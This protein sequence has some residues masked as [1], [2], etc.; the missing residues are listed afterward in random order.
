MRK[1][2]AAALLFISINLFAEDTP[3]SCT[4]WITF[5]KPI[6]HRLHQV[7]TEGND[8]LYFSGYAWHNRYTYRPEKIKSFNENAWGGGLG[9]GF[10][11]EK[12]NFHGLYA[13]AFM[14]SHDHLEPAVGY[15]YLKMAQF[16]ENIKAGIGYSVIVTSRVDIN[17]NI[18]IA[19]IIPWASVFYKKLSMGATY[20]PG[21]A[22]AGNVLFL[23]GKYSLG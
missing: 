4:H 5:L 12:K 6:C 22:G 13:I 21:A 1:L 16:T 11:D 14:D 9:K 2:I 18:P 3:Q 7:W 8:E 10:F 17:H 19:G 15:A 23:I 20:I